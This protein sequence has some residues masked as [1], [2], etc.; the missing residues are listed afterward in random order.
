MNSPKDP[1]DGG[2][3][4]WFPGRC[5]PL[6]WA[7]TSPLPWQGGHL[8]HWCLFLVESTKSTSQMLVE[9]LCFHEHLLHLVVMSDSLRPHEL[10]HAR[11]PCFSLS[12]RVCSNSYPL[13]HWYHPTIS[14]SSPP[15]PLALSVFPRFRVFSNE[16]HQV[17]KVLELL[18]HPSSEYSGLISF[19]ID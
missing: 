18:L 10:Q 13:S 4:T 16:S 3:P 19:R 14:S 9:G 6:T 2:C 15:S 8:T 11:L 5:V 17:A 7:R 12:P 1:S